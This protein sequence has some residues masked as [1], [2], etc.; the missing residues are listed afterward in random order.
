MRL[1][2][3]NAD[4]ISKKTKMVSA[5]EKESHRLSGRR[6]QTLS[7]DLRE[8]KAENGEQL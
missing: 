5:A 6:Q 4:E 8:K 3:T 2:S 1:L 7:F